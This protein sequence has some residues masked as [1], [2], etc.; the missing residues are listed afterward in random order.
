MTAFAPSCAGMREHEIERRPRARVRT[1]R[2]KSRCCRRKCSGGPRHVADDG[3]RAHNDAAHDPKR[4]GD[5]IARQ[6]KSRGGQRMCIAHRHGRLNTTSRPRRSLIF[7][8]ALIC[9]PLHKSGGFYLLVWGRVGTEF[10][11]GGVFCG[12]LEMLRA[13][14]EP[15]ARVMISRSLKAR[16]FSMA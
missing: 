2:C 11:M 10:V 6:F 8:T 1:G 4:A 12:A 5:A 14:N 7:R 15:S 3:A 13:R 16:T 9:P